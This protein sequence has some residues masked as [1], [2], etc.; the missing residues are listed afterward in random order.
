MP[1]SSVILSGAPVDAAV[2]AR[3]AEEVWRDL[4]DPDTPAFELRPLDDGAA[5]QVVATDIPVM[6]VLRPR[7]LPAADELSRVLPGEV[8][9]DDAKWWG[10]TYT[11]WEPA[12]RIGLAV[13]DVIATLVGGRAV[14]QGLAPAEGGAGGSRRGN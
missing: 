10:E 3:A 14:H 1:R 9:P 11:P 5:L 8:A 2:V 12:G 4:A 6:T 13:V 7:L